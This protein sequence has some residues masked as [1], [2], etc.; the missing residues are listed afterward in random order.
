MAAATDGLRSPAGSLI[1]RSV[2][3][4]DG[5]HKATG[6]FAYGTDVVV[7]GML[8]GRVARSPYPHARIRAIDTSAALATPGVVAVVTGRDLPERRF[9]ALVKDETVLAVDVVR[10]VGQPVAAVAALAVEAAIEAAARIAVE[11]DPLPAV[12]TPEA[13]LRAGA[14]LVH[15][16]WTTYVAHPQLI[17]AGNVC[18]AATIAK[19]DPSR[20][21]ADADH[22]FEDVFTTEPVHQAY[23]EPRVA[24][25]AWEPPGVLTVHSNTQLPFEAQ[26]V[27]ADLLGIPPGR[28][29]VITTGI[30]GAFGGKLR[31]GVEHIA[32]VLAQRVGRPVRIVLTMAEEFAAA[33][34]R[35][36]MRITLR[37]GVRRDGTIVAK[38]AHA[39]LDAGAFGG[40]S[41]GLPSV[42][43]LV[44]AG[45][46]RIP[47]LSIEATSVYTHKQNFGSYRAPTGPQCAF[48][49]E[50]QMDMIAR[51][52]RLDPLEFRLRNIVRD[53]DEGPSGQVFGKVSLEA[54]LRKAAAAIGWGHRRQPHHGKGLACSWWTTTGGPSAVYARLHADGT[55][56]LATG[57]A[58]IGTGALTAVAQIF[59]DD[60]GLPVE[61]VT[62]I[63]ADTL[64]TP[65]DHGAQGSRSTFAVGN[66]ARAAAADIRRQVLGLAA[67]VLEAR[68]SDLDLR[69]GRV[70]VRGTPSRQVELG[71]VVRLAMQRHGGLV[72]SGTFVAPATPYKTDCV[73]GH[74][75][76]AFHA[77]S[78]HA[79][80]AEVVVDP[81]TGTVRALRYV[82]AQ[83]VGKA[84]NPRLIEGQI[85]GGVVQGLGQ[86]LRERIA[87]QGAYPLVHNFSDYALPRCG[88]VPQI[89]SIL[90]EEPSDSGPHGARGVG[91]PPIITPPAA[92]ANAVHDAVGARVTDLP[93][94]PERVLRAMRGRLEG[95]A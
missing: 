79:H 73:S 7:A 90:I 2:P 76:P 19:G 32:A 95:A 55:A 62:L 68:V 49:V 92:I 40:S 28:V 14:P 67:E 86:A 6:R 75:Y 51:R 46:Y 5:F 74:F 36:A 56:T 53:G 64:A 34:P 24:I 20:G 45:P 94:S 72:S 47:H 85:E 30:G 87:Y 12:D 43:T 38:E 33:Y 27:L 26:T 4:L 69:D 31:V 17:R 80:A 57:C 63:S 89:T 82:V 77:P 84:I 39:L 37:T 10:Y 58:E 41:P 50:S 21:L 81:E 83:D 71:D 35:H 44:L 15:E 16:A 25:A 54:A 29:R 18:G 60:L 59:A 48:A 65:Y 42:A 13:A 52:L 61:N 91:E 66:A 8:H 3:R 11:Y 78:F 93:L 88:D 1:G 70:Y 23:L 9:G 22:V